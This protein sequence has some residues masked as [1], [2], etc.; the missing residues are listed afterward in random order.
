MHPPGSGAQ[1]V[2]GRVH[3][4]FAGQVD[5]ASHLAAG[6]AGHGLVQVPLF[7]VLGQGGAAGLVGLGIGQFQRAGHVDLVQANAVSR[8]PLNR[9]G[10]VFEFDGLVADVVAD[11]NMFAHHVAQSRTRGASPERLEEGLNL[12]G[13][14]EQ[15]IRFWFN[16]QPNDAVGLGSDVCQG[17]RHAQD[18]FE[19][20]AKQIGAARGGLERQRQGRDA[21]LGPLGQEP[22]QQTS[23]IDGVIWPPA[24]C[25][26][27]KVDLLFHAALVKVAIGKGIEG[28]ADH[29][30]ALQRLPEQDELAGVFES[31]RTT[32]AASQSPTA[33]GWPRAA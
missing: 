7:D 13:C 1:E 29:S 27:G 19:A 26:V 10:H 28:V 15:A 18:V 9:G 22:G 4:Q 11:A 32:G 21:A 20:M 12:V 17:A 3:N 2:I 30:G 6:Q 5:R 8:Q 14:F 33:K 16:G 23:A 25:P 24:V 31:S